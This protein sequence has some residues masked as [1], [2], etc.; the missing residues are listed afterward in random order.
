M[1]RVAY[2][3]PFRPGMLPWRLEIEPQVL[4]Y[5]TLGG[6]RAIA[7]RPRGARLAVS[8]G[9][10]T[11]AE[12]EHDALARCNEGQDALDPCFLYASG[13]KVIFPARRTAAAR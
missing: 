2:T 10:K 5:P 8:G 1:E 12:A 4:A 11:I 6:G 9:K 7:V 3:G 13:L